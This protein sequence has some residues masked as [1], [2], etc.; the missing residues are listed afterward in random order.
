MEICIK[1]MGRISDESSKR[2]EIIEIRDFWM[3][4]KTTMSNGFETLGMQ[5]CAPVDDEKLAEN[6]KVLACHVRK[7]TSFGQKI[8]WTQVQATYGSPWNTIAS[9][10]SWHNSENF[11][12][13]NMIKAWRTEN[14]FWSWNL[15][16]IST[17]ETI[18]RVFLKLNKNFSTW[19]T[20]SHTVLKQRITGNVEIQLNFDYDPNFV[21]VSDFYG[22]SALQESSSTIF[23]NGSLSSL[24][25]F[26]S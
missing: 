1:T 12:V 21:Y 8:G 13:W 3:L 11:F 20:N 22:Q 9:M 18:W 14:T 2:T 26:L 23:Q 6:V 4:P 10:S 17:T 7:L 19:V 24:W 16:H 5:V 25:F 15:G